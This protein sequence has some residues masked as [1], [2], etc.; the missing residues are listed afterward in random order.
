MTSGWAL[1]LHGSC[2]RD[3][4]FIA[5]PWV[6]RHPTEVGALVKCAEVEFER[7]AEGPTWKPHGRIAYAF[8]AREWTGERPRNVGRVVRGR[9][10]RNPSRL[11]MSDPGRLSVYITAPSGVTYRLADVRRPDG[12]VIKPPGFVP[13]N[14]DAAIR[15][16]RCPCMFPI[17]CDSRPGCRATTEPAR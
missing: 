12:K 11:R 3:L 13:P 17:Q 7:L 14:M 8:H 10:Q 2:Q 16:A 15:A 5:V 4:D 9:P 1:A 6:E